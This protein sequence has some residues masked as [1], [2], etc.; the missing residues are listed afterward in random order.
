VDRGMRTYQ[1]IVDFLPTLKAT[2]HQV[3]TEG[4]L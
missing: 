1:E 4:T 2:S 3:L